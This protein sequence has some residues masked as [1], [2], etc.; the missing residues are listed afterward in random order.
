MG[1]KKRK[2]NYTDFQAQGI[3]F[4]D[5]PSYSHSDVWR[6]VRN[7]YES[8]HPAICFICGDRD[9]MNLHH[10]RY[11]HLGHEPDDDLV[12]LC[13]HHHEMTHKMQRLMRWPFEEAHLC[14]KRYL[15]DIKPNPV[16]LSKKRRARRKAR[17]NPVRPRPVV[18]VADVP[19]E[20]AKLMP[21]RPLTPLRPTVSLTLR[22]VREQRP[23]RKKG[24][25]FKSKKS[26]ADKKERKAGRAGTNSSFFERKQTSMSAMI[27][28]EQKILTERYERILGQWA[29]AVQHGD[30]AEQIR[31]GKEKDNIWRVLAQI[32]VS[33]HR[34]VG[35]PIT[36]DDLIGDHD[37]GAPAEACT[38]AKR[39]P[40]YPKNKP[41]TR[42]GC[43]YA[44]Q[45]TYPTVCDAV[46]SI[47][48][49]QGGFNMTQVVGRVVSAIPE[50]AEQF[51]GLRGAEGKKFRRLVR[52]N[53]GNV[54]K[55]RVASNSITGD[56]E[57]EIHGQRIS[58]TQRYFV[59]GDDG[60]YR[61][62]SGVNWRAHI[63]EIRKGGYNYLL[64]KFPP[65]SPGNA[66]I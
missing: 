61:P 49:E 16:F 59:R 31:F 18:A 2:L 38:P 52:K 30:V 10:L 54:V 22:D 29:D 57:Y 48:E 63:A 41:G 46:E 6:S 40:A 14:L 34:T 26:L 13:R 32:H 45:L 12:W 65:Q 64:I 11:T 7:S 47:V 8:R 3:G 25:S 66:T 20:P 42:N 53:I 51:F 50:L 21:R 43:I 60:I 5:Y 62:A 15:A 28:P 24:R 19:P 4:P 44:Q 36:A 37:F 17:L 56:R 23:A 39:E 1:R 33:E 55:K 58:A 27:S 9:G 35:E